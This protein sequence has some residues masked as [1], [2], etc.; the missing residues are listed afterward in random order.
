LCLLARRLKLRPMQQIQLA[1]A[2]ATMM[3]L[4]HVSA[5]VRFLLPAPALC[6]IQRRR[7]L[8]VH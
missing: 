5:Q 3:P 8:R 6:A 7:F 1:L 2:A 4:Q